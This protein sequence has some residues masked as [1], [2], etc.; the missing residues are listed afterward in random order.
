MNAGR[1][2]SGFVHYSYIASTGSARVQR[3]SKRDLCYFLRQTTREDS[4]FSDMDSI[5]HPFI[6][7]IFAVT[8]LKAQIAT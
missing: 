6:E 1:S 2:Q 3:K 7:Q 4:Q 5:S 8:L